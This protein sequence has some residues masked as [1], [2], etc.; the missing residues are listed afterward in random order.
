MRNTLLILTCSALLMAGCNLNTP[1]TPTVISDASGD[2]VLA[3]AETA[4]PTVP[5]LPTT[6][7][8]PTLPPTP[9]VPPEQLLLL[10]D[11]QL[12]NGTFQDAAMTYQVILRQE[13][14]PDAQAAAYYGIGR[15]M[16][17]EG[18]FVEAVQHLTRLVED[19]PD[20]EYA[21]R[22]RFLR[23]EAFLGT[24]EWQAAIDD[25]KAY[26]TLRPGMLD[27]YALER[28]A[29]AQLALGQLEAALASYQQAT[30]ASR[31]LVPAL[32]LRER[33]ALVLLNAGRVDEAVAQYDAI[34]A[35][36]QN[37]AY[38]A[39]IAMRA[40]R[41]LLDAGNTEA[42]LTRMATL[43]QEWPETPHGY[44]AMQ[45]LRQNAQPVDEYLRG[46]VAFAYGDYPAA[47]DALNRW[48][49]SRSSVGEIPAAFHLLLGQAYRALGNTEAA[50]TAFQT[51]VE[52]FKTDPLFGAALLEQG[53]TRF[54]ADDIPGAIGAYVSIADAYGYLPEAAEALWRAGYLY[55]TNDQPNEANV[56]F[57]RLA[58]EHPATQQAIDGLFL[59]AT[60]AYRLGNVSAAERYYAELGT[61]TTGE[62]QAT[63]YF[64]LG[65]LALQRGD[66]TAAGQAFGQ[67]IGAA[68]DSFFAAR[69][70]DI[71]DGRA[72]FAPPAQWTF[73]FDDAAQIAEAEN[74]LRA[75]F[76]IEQA[77]AL[78]PL[79]PELTAAT[80]RGAELWAVGAI[81]E[82]GAEFDSVV[83]ANRENALAS[84]QLA[85][86]LRGIGA[87]YYSL[88]ASS[89]V[90]RAANVGTLAAPAFIARMRYPAYYLDLVLREAERYDF[91]PLLLLSLMR[92]ES[93]FNTYA[94][95]AAGEKGLTQVVPGTAQYIAEQ[96]RFP[97]YQHSDLFSP[98]AGVAFGAFYLNEQLDRFDQNAVA[99]LAG[100]NAGPGRA[101]EWLGV[102]GDDPD[103]FMTAI[104]IDSTRIY[105]ERIYGYHAIYRALYGVS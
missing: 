45:I 19:F 101:I 16:L 100:Y 57:E 55:S 63:A 23:G 93:L 15:A 74:W 46:R 29:D 97:D 87:Y 6:T 8:E 85:I 42:A 47:V 78:W 80:V 66:S 54:L 73:S 21:V 67:V 37:A 25:F 40:A 43:L 30:E 14:P 4:L 88:L 84:Y 79:S 5:V 13:A 61:K 2:L 92:H 9:T 26:M 90:I 48:A 59:A 35:A 20:S 7:P 31:A 77:G 71:I 81:D 1:E 34:L 38:R 33:A 99:A 53:R 75:T 44:E 36:S 24:S 103:Q 22:G 98:Y 12:L 91:D 62:D 49:S 18:M 3:Q 58:D 82:A 96:I 52:S 50:V 68:P 32:A 69:A 104:T 76:A 94:T 95:A 70:R 27:S 64:W 51:I 65:R 11:R 39:D 10:G 83:E 60:N 56:L 86:Y 102:A 72:A 17:L 41:A 89:Y 105:V 28:T